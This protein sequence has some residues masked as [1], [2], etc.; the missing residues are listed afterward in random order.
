LLLV[1][2]N[3]TWIGEKKR[4]EGGG[5]LPGAHH[6]L[7]LFGEG[8]GLNLRRKSQSRK[9]GQSKMDWRKKNETH[10]TGNT[11]KLPSLQ[12]PTPQ[13]SL[14]RKRASN[15]QRKR[16]PGRRKKTATLK[17]PNPL[18]SKDCWN[19]GNLGKNGLGS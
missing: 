8:K 14:T 3:K 1:R 19:N 6:G 7:I 5:K 4:I 11:K 16:K 2:K 13:R 9:R 17:S 15:C 12:L 18:R 10:I